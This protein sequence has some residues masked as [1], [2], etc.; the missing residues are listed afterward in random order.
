MMSFVWNKGFSKVVATLLTALLA[1]TLGLSEA[2]AQ[3]DTESEK[4]S[5]VIIGGA[6]KSDNAELYNRMIELA[7]GKQNAIIGIFPT[8]SASMSSSKE[9]KKDFED[10][11]VPADQ[12]RIIEITES[13][14]EQK[15]N[16][17]G[18][19]SEISECTAFFF[20][21]GDQA[22][23]TKAFYNRDGSNTKALDAVWEVY[24]NG[25]MVAG[26]SAGAAIMSKTMI[27]NATSLEA[28]QLGVTY[29]EQKPGLWV[30]KGLGFF[31][32]GIVDQH[33]SKRGR[34]GRLVVAL[35]QE[36]VDYGF[37]IDENSAMVVT[38]PE[39]QVIGESGM[40]LIDASKASLS[41]KGVYQD[42]DVSYLEKGDIY[43]YVT[44]KFT[45]EPSKTLIPKG[46]EYYEGNQLNTNIFGLDAAKLAL[47][48]DL[49]DNTAD[50]ARGLSFTMEQ[51]KDKGTGVSVV[52]SKTKATN[53][54][55]DADEY[56]T[57]I[58]HVNMEIT[59]IEVQVKEVNGGK[60]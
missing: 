27:Q 18:V 2:N 47:L 29:D 59:P 53:G 3:A 40:F 1:V 10:Y 31:D 8:A 7:G 19:V 55:Y 39:I 50:Q 35:V 37:G 34:I 43:N 51:K 56:A 57:S 11:G 49:A 33:F 46:K 48:D 12:V 6:N 16:D 58:L 20:V 25:G 44:K 5:L 22:R 45:L 21:G 24:Q 4:G 17:E 38:G 42:L 15:V 14:Y 30:T 23:I 60:K 13:N 54:Y 26:T 52:F 41:K 28:L 9:M 36:K 32:G